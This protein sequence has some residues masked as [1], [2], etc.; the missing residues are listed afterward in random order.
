MHKTTF[1]A[2]SIVKTPLPITIPEVNPIAANGSAKT[3]WLNLINDRY[4]LITYSMLQKYNF[5]VM[6]VHSA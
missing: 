4:F 2:K 3:V 6:Q 1:N 5:D